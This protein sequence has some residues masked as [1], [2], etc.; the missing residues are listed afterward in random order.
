MQDCEIK[1]VNEQVGE[2]T[3]LVSGKGIMPKAM[4]L[5]EISCKVLESASAVINFK[6]PFNKKSVIEISLDTDNNDVWKMISKKKSIIM[7][8]LSYLQIP[9]NFMPLNIGKSSSTLN[10]FIGNIHWTYPII[11]I[12]E[13]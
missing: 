7:D 10:I 11:G 5:T 12:T 3:F 8:P 13:T 1:F 4:E 6:N 9:I 2:V